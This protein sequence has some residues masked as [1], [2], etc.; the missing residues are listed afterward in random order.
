MR[1]GSD[2]PGSP[3]GL[4]SELEQTELL[5]GERTPS[6][7]GGLASLDLG[8][9]GGLPGVGQ[10]GLRSRGQGLAFRPRERPS[11]T[12]AR[13]H[14][15]SS[16]PSS[17]RASKG[18]QYNPDSCPGTGGG[19]RVTVTP[20]PGGAVTVW[21]QAI[22][23]H[24]PEDTQVPSLVDPRLSASRHGIHN[25]IRPGSRVPAP[26]AGSRACASSRCVVGSPD[27]VVLQR[28][29]PRGWDLITSHD[30]FSLW[31]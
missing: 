17:V 21:G 2:F 5:H 6:T 13:R 3:V 10:S 15:G 31:Y 9:C 7:H 1:A 28:V 27:T 20:N 24:F 25:S 8:H 14:L 23:T 11:P 16:S 29:R 26:T 19:H 12:A 4:V 30:Y 22:H 18:L